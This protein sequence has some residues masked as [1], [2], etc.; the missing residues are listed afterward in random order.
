M[1]N[2]ENIGVLINHLKELP[3]ENF[4]MADWI[5]ERSCGTVACIAGYAALLRAEEDPA[6]TVRGSQVYFGE[7][8]FRSVPAYAADWLGLPRSSASAL[9]LPLPLPVYPG[10]ADAIRMLEWLYG[11]DYVP[12]PEDI[13]GEWYTLYAAGLWR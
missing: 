5:V 1:L 2:K 11:L 10:L 7:D 4:D 13:R 6:L 3:P 12:L 8:R 9:F